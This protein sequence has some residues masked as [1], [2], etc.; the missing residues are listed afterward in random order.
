MGIFQKL[1][2]QT[3]IYGV[4]TVVP[5]M[6]SFIL[7]PFYVTY[8]TSRA[9][10]GELSIVFAWMA[11]FN[12]FLAYG[13]ETSFFRFFS[14]NSEREK[15]P[16]TASLSLVISSSLFLIIAFLLKDW[17][18][19]TTSIAPHYISFVIVIL[20]LDA[21]VIVPFAWLRARE[22]PKLFAIIKIGNVAINL[23]FN[24]FF[25]VLLPDLT[26]DNSF[27][28]SIYKPHFQ[29]AYI[30]IANLFASG[31]TLL[32]MLP[33]YLKMKFAF[34]AQLWRKMI[35]YGT[36]ILIA[37]IGYAINEVMDK[38]ILEHM[39]PAGIAEAEV[40][41]YAACYKLALFMTLF[42]TAFRMGIEPFFFSH[43]NNQDARQTYAMITKY[44]VI[45]G[46]IILVTVTIFADVLKILLIPNSSYWE[47][48]TVVPII[49]L[50]NLFLGIYHN[51]SVW[52]KVSDRTRFA[53]YIS[54]FGAVV[55]LLLNFWLI[56][57]FSYV[58][59][60][61]ATLA[62]YAS[63]TFLSYYYGRK[64]YRVPYE[65]RK[66]GG[67]LL[68]AIV[69]SGISFY[70]FRY[71]YFMGIILLLTFFALIYFAEKKELYRLLKRK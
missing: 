9:D 12:I 18:A 62:A 7:L 3:A 19:A 22:R 47:A 61:I 15:V 37:G 45:F 67:Y 57:Y 39:L 4:A 56:P 42:V 31:L 70:G 2:K 46:A 69:I 11:L 38:I 29:I 32:V 1:F 6:L 59:S 40:G 64:F 30:F 66:I 10:Y 36:P 23:G 55:T 27:F 26:K 16:G 49:L 13:M 33:V 21:L 50:A 20:A 51:L 35:Q 68:L 5:R 54:L 25:L 24:I 28:A 34:D 44:F 65:T 8:L 58:G 17:I 43:A 60:A 41:A 48:M 63:M 53:A 52:Y 14:E 71:N